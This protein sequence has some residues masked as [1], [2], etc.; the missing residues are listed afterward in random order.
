MGLLLF[1]IPSLFVL[2]DFV[3][4]LIKGKR[5]Y[6]SAFYIFLD[7]V[8]MV[9]FPLLFLFV[10]D[11]AENDCCSDSAIFSPKHK[12]TI[13]ALIGIVLLVYFYSR[14]KNKIQ[15]PIIEV[16]INSMLIIGIIFNGFMIYHVDFISVFDN[17]AIIMILIMELIDNQKLFREES[18]S[19]FKTAT[20][21]FEKTAWKI[22]N[23]S[24]IL[25][26]PVLLIICLPILFILS[27]FLLIFGQ[28]PDSIIRG[29]TDTY[30][31]GFS[32]LDYM[33][34]NVECG[35]HFLCSVAANG[36]KKI[37]QPN[38]YGERGGNKIICNRQLL[39]SNA[40]EELL[41]DNL[42]KTHK[43]IRHNYNKVGD[44]IHKYYGF[45]NNKFV[46]DII[47]VLMKPLEWIFLITLYFFDKNPENRIAKQYL[48]PQ[49]RQKIDHKI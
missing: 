26:F 29:F 2:V 6:G 36:H 35:G 13:Y 32:Q 11:S 20:N 19:T 33:C 10:L 5:L 41:Q 24:P 22:L 45:F 3:Y 42:P 34:D 48:S 7:F 38:R 37:V 31:H 27:S 18:E 21:K 44:V 30:K 9:F 4:L 17:Y 47:Y 16:L 23:L 25:K 14:L 43:I 49:D 39:I 1:L 12:I 28:K 8:I 40:F 15:S 46:S